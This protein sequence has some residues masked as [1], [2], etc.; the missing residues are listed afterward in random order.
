MKCDICDIDVSKDS[1][2]IWCSKCGWH[3]TIEQIKKLYEFL[4][5]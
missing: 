2:K 1:K 3:F 4:N 5:G